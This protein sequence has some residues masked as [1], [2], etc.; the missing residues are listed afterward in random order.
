MNKITL[1]FYQIYNFRH[2]IHDEN[3]VDQLL[4]NHSTRKNY[5]TNYEVRN[6]TPSETHPLNMTVTCGI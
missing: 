5:E 4:A 3:D 2:H 6:P 1:F